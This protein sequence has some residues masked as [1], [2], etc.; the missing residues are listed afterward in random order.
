MNLNGVTSCL[1][2]NFYNAI[3]R[4]F[5]NSDTDWKTNQVTIAK[6]N[7][8]TFVTVICQDFI[9]SSH[10]ACFKFFCQGLRFFILDIDSNQMHIKW[11]QFFREIDSPSVTVFTFWRFVN[12]EASVLLHHC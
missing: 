3:G 8:D 4:F 7:T 11:C 6:F 1:D 2:L 9:T 10:Q 12:K 5:T